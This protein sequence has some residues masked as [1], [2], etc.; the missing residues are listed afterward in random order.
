MASY[1]VTIMAVEDG[2]TGIDQVIDGSLSGGIISE[3]MVGA[4]NLP[5]AK[6]HDDKLGEAAT[7]GNPMSHANPVVQV[8]KLLKE[9]DVKIA[10][11]DRYIH[12]VK[13]GAD[14][15]GSVRQKSKLSST[16][17]FQLAKLAIERKKVRLKRATNK[18]K[19]DRWLLRK[20][21]EFRMKQGHMTTVSREHK[22]Q[23]AVKE[24]T[25]KVKARVADEVIRERAVDAGKESLV[26]EVH[27]RRRTSD[28][29][30]R[31]Y[32]PNPDG[33]DPAVARRR[34]ARHRRRVLDKSVKT[35]EAIKR[36]ADWMV[37]RAMR[38]KAKFNNRVVKVRMIPIL[39]ICDERL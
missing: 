28:P 11:R 1:R 39:R 37:D 7:W 2:V 21:N 8:V 16:L 19:E 27:R 14:A 34:A 4:R 30:A 20:M 18:I 31:Y 32:V 17:R 23:S 15:G 29:T 9:K 12:H 22:L 6:R 24:R 3:K 35:M 36:R 10:T 33:Y 25:R 13:G 26:K 38:T 5:Q